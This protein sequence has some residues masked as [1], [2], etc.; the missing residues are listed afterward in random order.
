[1]LDSILSF[2]VTMVSLSLFA[3]LYITIMGIALVGV[4]MFLL[5]LALELMVK[6]AM[7]A[8][9]WGKNK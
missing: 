6:W 9:K 1:M 2:V 3:I 8:F 5:Y 4:I 7:D